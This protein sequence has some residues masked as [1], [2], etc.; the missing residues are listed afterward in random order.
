[1]PSTLKECLAPLALVL[2]LGL[3]APALAQEMAPVNV[4]TAD[5][6]LLAELPGIGE[7]KAAAIVEERQ[8]N[9]DFS[10]AED[11]TRVDGIGESTVDALAD[12]VSF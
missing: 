2:L 5:A 3:A 1:M 7:I 11:L 6:A 12:Q 9:G 4:N 10:S 8:A